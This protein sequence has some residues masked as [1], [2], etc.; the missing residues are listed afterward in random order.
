MNNSIVDQSLYFLWENIQE[1][2]FDQQLQLNCNILFC[3]NIL[4]DSILWEIKQGLQRPLVFPFKI[5]IG[6]SH[7]EWIQIIS[8]KKKSNWVQHGGIYHIVEISR[9]TD[10]S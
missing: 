9:I 1:I 8:V 6:S 2:K 4:Y 7:A 3:Y 10:S 5:Y